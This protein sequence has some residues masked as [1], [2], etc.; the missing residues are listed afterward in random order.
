MPS[1]RR[2]RKF[3][4]VPG[5]SR[6][7]P[8]PCGSGLKYKRCCLRGD[9]QDA[10]NSAL[11]P[12]ETLDATGRDCHWT[13][14]ARIAAGGSVVGELVE[15]ACDGERFEVDR[16]RGWLRN[17]KPVSMFSVLDALPPQL[18]GWALET[19]LEAV[20]DEDLTP[21]GMDV[22]RVFLLGSAINEVVRVHAPTKLARIRRMAR[23]RGAAA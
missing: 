3:G 15:H 7:S 1:I 20:S 21:L 12:L 6:N 17:G 9:S 18:N 10:S 13:I 16:Q 22:A 8:C 11:R 4:P 14:F 5:V 19:A 2:Q 23:R